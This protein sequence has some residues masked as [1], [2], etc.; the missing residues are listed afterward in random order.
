MEYYKREKGVSY[1]KATR[2]H[3][4]EKM[5]QEGLGDGN[6]GSH[7]DISQLSPME[8]NVASLS[9]FPVPKRWDKN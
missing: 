5:E 4:W 2:K 9:T 8:A 7:A 1:R 3:K 6:A